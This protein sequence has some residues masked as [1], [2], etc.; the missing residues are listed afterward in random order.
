[1]CTLYY[2]FMYTCLAGGRIHYLAG[3]V[4]LQ[5]VRARSVFP[6]T[7]VNVADKWEANRRKLAKSEIVSTTADRTSQCM[8]F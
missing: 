8:C 1:M 7:R 6:N 2:S 5:L 3:K 4:F